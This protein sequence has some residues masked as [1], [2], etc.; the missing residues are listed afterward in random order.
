MPKRSP[1]IVC[2]TLLL[3]LGGAPACSA[4]KPEPELASSAPHGHYAREFPDKLNAVAKDFSDRRIE[5]R[6]VFTEFNGYPSKLKDPPSWAHVLE[7]VTRAD[8]D[9]H[10][11]AYVG[12]LRRVAGASAFFEAEI[13]EINKKVAGSVAFVAKKKGC[14]ESVAGAAA[15]ALKDIV[16]KQLEKELHE[17]SEAHR[18]IDRYRSEL[19]KEN[20]AA[21]EKQADDIARAS[22]VVHIELVDDK[23]RL[24]RM[25]GEVDQVR[26]TADDAIAAER[27]YQ[28]SY[29][30][31]TEAEKK[32][33]QARIDELNKSKASLDAAVKQAEAVVP[34]VEDEIKKIQKEYDDALEA[35]KAKIK[36]KVH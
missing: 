14:D 34:T 27:D 18:L 24:L 10:S 33:S 6:K 36:E 22:Y 8:E 12:R 20:A 35:L 16:E 31:M 15:P 13:D 5:A 3:G 26:K 4:P 19:G 7:I 23:L 29:K 1:F 32:A 30:K 25:V 28:S 2:V 17:A 21:L 9:G 11:H